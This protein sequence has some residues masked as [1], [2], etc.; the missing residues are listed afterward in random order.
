[1]ARGSSSRTDLGELAEAAAGGDSRAVADLLAVLQPR[2]IRY[3]RARINPHNSQ[4][5]ADDVAQEV[6]LAALTAL[7]RFRREG[8]RFDA[9]VFGI[10]AHKVVDFHRKRMRDR[11]TAMEQVPDLGDDRAGP[12]QVALR[13]E[14]RQRLGRL[15]GCLTDTQREVVVLRLAVGMSS[16]EVARVLSSTPGAVRVAQHRALDRLRRSLEHHGDLT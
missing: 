13:T 5:S 16:E 9:F 7:P 6:M 3:C 15:L 8:S 10:A 12:E 1:M 11:A 2:V 14:L 4:A